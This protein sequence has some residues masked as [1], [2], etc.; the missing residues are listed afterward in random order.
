MASFFDL[1]WLKNSNAQIFKKSVTALAWC[2]VLKDIPVDSIHLLCL[3][4]VEFK[5]ECNKQ[6]TSWKTVMGQEKLKPAYDSCGKG[7]CA[8]ICLMSFVVYFMGL[9]FYCMPVWTNHETVIAAMPRSVEMSTLRKHGSVPFFVS[10]T[11][12][13]SGHTYCDWFY[14]AKVGCCKKAL[15][16][17]ALRTAEL[18]FASNSRLHSGSPMTLRLCHREAQEQAY[19]HHVLRNVRDCIKCVLQA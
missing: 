8:W 13:G 12:L 19:H 1:S 18:Y 10:R 17:F 4:K 7:H 6:K 9:L 3:K 5:I 14:V 2:L 16:R 11:Y 15:N